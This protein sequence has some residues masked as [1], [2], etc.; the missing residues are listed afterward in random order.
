MFINLI[1]DVLI[2]LKAATQKYGWSGA[3]APKDELKADEPQD[4]H[5]RN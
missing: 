5:T 3:K 2:F 1:G 4:K